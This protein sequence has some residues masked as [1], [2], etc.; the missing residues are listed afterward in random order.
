MVTNWISFV[1]FFHRSLHGY[2]NILTFQNITCDIIDGIQSFM[3]K[4]LRN[5]LEKKYERNN[6]EL[7]IDDLVHFFGVFDEDPASFIFFGGEKESIVQAADYL[8]EQLKKNSNYCRDIPQ[9]RFSN[10]DTITL[11]FGLI[12]GVEHQSTITKHHKQV[13]LKEDLYRLLV[14]LY[15]GIGKNA[16]HP[17]SEKLI[18]KIVNNGKQFRGE[19]L[20]IYCENVKTISVDT[21]SPKASQTL[22]WT[23][24]NL[25]AHINKN[26]DINTKK[27]RDKKTNSPQKVSATPNGKKQIE[28]IICIADGDD[29]V[30][31]LDTSVEPITKQQ[32]EDFEKQIYNQLSEQSNRISKPTLLNS[33][34]TENIA[35]MAGASQQFIQIAKIKGD[36]SCMF[37]AISH[38][39]HG[40][41]IDSLDHIEQTKSLRE[42]TVMHI[43]Q[44]M[45]RFEFVI[46]QRIL[47]ELPTN[48]DKKVRVSLANCQ[49]LVDD[50][51][52]RSTFWGGTES[53]MA[54][55]EMKQLNIF[56]IN[57]NDNF[58]FVNGFNPNFQHTVC[59]AYRSHR[60]HYDSITEINTNNLF[61]CAEH[62][63]KF[64]RPK[65]SF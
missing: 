47:D 33:E 43:R 54:I 42:E 53:L 60:K 49:R 34:K 2:S 27:Q 29:S 31:C 37:G 6:T 5:I 24:A 51:L 52:T 18:T 4:S 41:K 22:Y 44:N 17:I 23:L 20:C 35:F 36:G 65:Q 8:K 13:D 7:S 14:K 63:V 30:I 59:I 3:Q 39:I 12:F 50:H 40:T 56:I 19:V 10:K 48:S 58:Q 45:E 64:V 46:R 55:S 32:Q 62:L 15:D 25:K 11:P 28:E 1:F 16:T 26:H 61:G 9:L 38:Q 57:E 21:F